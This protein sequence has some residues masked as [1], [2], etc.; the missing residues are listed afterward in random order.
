MLGKNY[1][2]SVAKGESVYPC[3]TV[4]A[5]FSCAPHF[6]KKSPESLKERLMVIVRWCF[7]LVFT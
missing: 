2:V 1:T 5:G 6:I 7:G 4:R 3:E